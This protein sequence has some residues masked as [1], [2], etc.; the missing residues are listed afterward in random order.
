[1][2][3]TGCADS[4]PTFDVVRFKI[5]DAITALAGG[6]QS[7]TTLDG[8]TSFHRVTTVASGNDSVT[9]P[10][11]RAGMFLIV[12]SATSNANSLNVFPAKGDSINA[13]SPN[14][15]FAVAAGKVAVFV[16]ASSTSAAGIW[17]SVTT[18]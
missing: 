5:A 15:A 16:C 2:S 11:A 17:H 9:L 14:T 12:V 18:A 7:A 4:T 3:S 6:G 1:M 8:A 10:Q 13:L